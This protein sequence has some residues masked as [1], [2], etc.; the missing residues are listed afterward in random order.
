[1]KKTQ[2]KKTKKNLQN[3]MKQI[4]G[5]RRMFSRKHSALQQITQN[6][7]NSYQNSFTWSPSLRGRVEMQAES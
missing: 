1:M 4:C 2:G 6:L 3:S 5:H 7:G